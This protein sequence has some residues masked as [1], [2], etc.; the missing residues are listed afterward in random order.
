MFMNKYFSQFF[1][2]LLA[3]ILIFALMGEFMLMFL[4][5]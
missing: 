3:V 2:W 1:V 5:W 4:V